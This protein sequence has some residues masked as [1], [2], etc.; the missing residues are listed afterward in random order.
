MKITSSQTLVAVFL[1]VSLL[2][3]LIAAGVDKPNILWITSEDHGPHMG[4]Y[5]DAN[6]TTP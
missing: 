6:A 3:R 5:G 1:F 2:G 4:C